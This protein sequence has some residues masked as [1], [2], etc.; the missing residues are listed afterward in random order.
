MCA[1]IKEK[2]GYDNS[3]TKSNVKIFWNTQ[4]IGRCVNTPGQNNGNA[5][6]SDG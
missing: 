5:C 4:S 1:T 6:I 2:Y 3:Q